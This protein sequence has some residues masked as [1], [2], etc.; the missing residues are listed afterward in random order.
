[1]SSDEVLAREEVTRFYTDRVTEARAELAKAQAEVDRC[2]REQAAWIERGHITNEAMAGTL[3]MEVVL[4][5]SHSS[6]RYQKAG[7]A[8]MKKSGDSVLRAVAEDADRRQEALRRWLTAEGYDL[9]A[10]ALPEPKSKR[11]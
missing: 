10:M 4:I 8:A 1:M 7:F 6:S 2:E 9:G 3:R 11:R 5:V